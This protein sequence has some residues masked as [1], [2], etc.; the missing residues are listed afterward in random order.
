MRREAAEAAAKREQAQARASRVA[1]AE[2]ARRC[3]EEEKARSEVEEERRRILV[4]PIQDQYYA[5]V[6]EGRPVLRRRALAHSLCRLQS[7]QDEW[8]AGAGPPPQAEG[9]LPDGDP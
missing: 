8:P 1:D 3:V 4:V 6:P 2:Q 7:G 9:V 5:W